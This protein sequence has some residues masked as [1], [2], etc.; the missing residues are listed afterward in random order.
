M[1]KDSMI[2]EEYNSFDFELKKISALVF[3]KFKY[4][5]LADKQIYFKSHHHQKCFCQESNLNH[6]SAVSLFYL[7]LLLI[8]I[9]LPMIQVFC[10][11]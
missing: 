10:L 6:V 11:S 9:L 8:L 3:F 1:Q 7:A 5:V 4:K 2:L